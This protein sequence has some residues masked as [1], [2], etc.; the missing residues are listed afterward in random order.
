MANDNLIPDFDTMTEHATEAARLKALEIILKAD[1]QCLEAQ[2]VREAIVNKDYW[3][4]DKPP[5]MSYCD[6]VVRVIGNTIEE[7]QRLENLRK[8]IAAVTEQLSL[9]E[10]LIFIEKNKLDLYRTLCANERTSLF[11]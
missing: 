9:M 3:T 11:A 4:S 8:E 7:C 6:A 5:S 2:C 1:L 10:A